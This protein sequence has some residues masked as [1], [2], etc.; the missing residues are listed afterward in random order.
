MSCSWHQTT[1]RRILFPSIFFH[2][3]FSVWGDD[4]QNKLFTDPKLRK[5][6]LWPSQNIYVNLL[7]C[8][9]HQTTKTTNLVFPNYFNKFF[10]VWAVE[11]ENKLFI[12]PKQ[13]FFSQF[14]SNKKLF[15]VFKWTEKNSWKKIE[16]NKIGCL[17]VWCHKQDTSF[18]NGLPAKSIFTVIFKYQMNW[19]K[20]SMRLIWREYC[21][22]YRK[23][24]ALNVPSERFWTYYGFSYYK[25]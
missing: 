19:L 17:V 14:W 9:W 4:K 6:F 22:V 25:K 18:E 23:N 2:E 21:T 1:K 11:K 10:S 5:Q 15:F 20:G 8:S 3:F 12:G 24:L 7:T 16:G 13:V